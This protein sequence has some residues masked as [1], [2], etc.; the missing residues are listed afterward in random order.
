M[1]RILKD[2][3]MLVNWTSLCRFNLFGKEIVK[4]GEEI[5]NLGKEMKTIGKQNRKLG[6][7]I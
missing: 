5:L 4:I 6:K 1:N 2:K 7:H 3:G